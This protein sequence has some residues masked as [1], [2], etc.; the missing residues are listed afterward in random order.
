MLLQPTCDCQTVTDISVSRHDIVLAKMK[1]DVNHMKSLVLAL[2]SKDK[3]SIK[4]R[5]FIEPS[6]LCRGGNPSTSA[7]GFYFVIFALIRA[8][9]PK[10]VAIATVGLNLHHSNIAYQSLFRKEITL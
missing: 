6:L 7:G 4:H 2:T 8:I 10:E 9:Q 5:G 1:A 3:T